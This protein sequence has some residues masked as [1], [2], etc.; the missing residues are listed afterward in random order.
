MIESFLEQ[1]DQ[2][3]V[4][5]AQDRVSADLAGAAAFYP[6]QA[7]RVLRMAIRRLAVTET[8]VQRVLGSWLHRPD[9]DS[10]A[11]TWIIAEELMRAPSGNSTPSELCVWCATTLRAGGSGDFVAFRSLAKEHLARLVDDD[12]EK[13]AFA[14]GG[15]VIWQVLY[16]LG[17][18]SR[19]DWLRLMSDRAA[20]RGEKD[21]ARR[22]HQL[23]DRFT[24]EPDR[25]RLVGHRRAE[26]RDSGI[27][28]GAGG[29]AGSRG[30]V[31]GIGI[32]STDT[33]FGFHPTDP[34]QPPGAHLPPTGSRPIG[35]TPVIREPA[36]PPPPA[37]PDFDTITRLI[38]RAVA[39]L[40]QGRGPTDLTEPLRHAT[41]PDQR[42]TLIF[43][44]ALA[45][46]RAGEL[47][48][49]RTTLRKVLAGPAEADTRDLVANAHLIV[50]LLDADVEQVAAGL[51]LLFDQ[52]GDSW[53][54]NSLLDPETMRRTLVS[55]APQKLAELAEASELVLLAR[56]GGANALCLQSARSLLAKA[57][58]AVHGSD[59]EV[60]GELLAQAI[61]IVERV[62]GARAE[63]PDLAEPLHLLHL[64]QQ[65][66]TAGEPAAPSPEP[67]VEPPEL[68]YDRLP[69]VLPSS[70]IDDPES[71]PPSALP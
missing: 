47:D 61:Q 51:R 18:G 34:T 54:D 64:A 13:L 22:R 5:R 67:D 58:C 56:E 69:L 1:A 41:D 59:N 17:P 49:A 43:L 23:A 44:S 53:A 24:P 14:G 2:S 9:P 15:S 71:T 25:N 46:L 55:A 10:F 19:S 3:A 28:F 50:G 57:A 11:R 26:S 48:R 60:A 29:G 7:I 63:E 38:L 37:P 4:Q 45:D 27:F 42:R 8:D 40:M 12:F 70:L 31:A 33:P 66:R 21:V 35:F 6:D 30:T 52:H 65:R 62:S 68:H 39:D 32:G 20:A 36:T 16:A